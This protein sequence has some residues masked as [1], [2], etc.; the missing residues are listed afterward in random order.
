MFLSIF[1]LALKN[2]LFFGLHMDSK[3]GFPQKLT[4]EE[5]QKCFFDMKKGGKIAENA[6]DKLIVHNLR[7]VAYIV[8]KNYSEDKDQEDLISIGIIGLIRACETY[9]HEKGVNF[10]TYATRCIDNQIKMHFRKSKKYQNE[11]SL[12]EPI[13][14][15]KDGNSITFEDIFKDN[16]NV[17]E[18]V[19]N[20]I[21]CEK[22]YVYIDEVLTKREKQILCLR[23]GL[24]AIC[25]REGKV[26]TQ[27]EVAKLLNI[28]RS[29]VSRLEKKAIE[30][31]NEKFIDED[32]SKDNKK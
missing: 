8:K 7:L 18:I 2:M 10:S 19:D 21:D 9:N 32:K 17:C 3:N 23:Y 12:N 5:E 22:L 29:Y 15:D 6:R 13:D 31:L 1:R 24:S 14:T 20:R 16:H 11:V 25:A 30:K 26:M 4:K 28:S 27:K